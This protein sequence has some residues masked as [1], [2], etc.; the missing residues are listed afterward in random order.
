MIEI[1]GFKSN[2]WRDNYN[3]LWGMNLPRVVSLLEA[4]ERGAFAD[5]QWFYH[6]MERSDAMIHAVVHRR[7][8]AI[9]GSGGGTQADSGFLRCPGDRGPYT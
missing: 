2:A 4:V 7:R 6:Y 1:K 8:A 5:L 9:A 3:P